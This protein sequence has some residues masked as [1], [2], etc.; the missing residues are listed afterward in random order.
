MTGRKHTDTKPKKRVLV[1]GAGGFI[2]SHLVERLVEKGYEVVCLVK[3]G[4]NIR[5][6]KHLD[7]TLKYGD[8]TEKESLYEPVKGIAY[9]YHLAASLGGGHKSSEIYTINYDGSKN[10]LDVCLETDLKLKRFLFASSTAAAGATDDSGIFNEEKPANPK[11]DYGK[12][13]LMVENY[14]KE[15]C[16]D[17]PY[18]IVRLPLVYGPRGL[19]GLYTVFKLVNKGFQLLLGKSDTNVGF[20]K[21]IVRGMIL[22]AENPISAGQTYFLGEDKIYNS[23][24]ITRHIVKAT[25]KKTIKVWIPYSIIYFLTFLIEKIADLFGKH[26]LIR[27]HSISAYLNSNWRFSMQKAKEELKFKAEYPLSEGLK[28]TADWYNEKGIIRTAKGK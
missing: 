8:I 14:L 3:P 10:L 13:K 26:P 12:S 27:T 2:G 24:E 7:V 19:G 1:T 4:E 16:K 25:G 5:W 18:T 23:R 22:A 20:V 15:T 17:I 28:I 21:D 11:T 9:I 6:I